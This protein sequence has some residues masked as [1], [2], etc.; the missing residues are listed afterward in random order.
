MHCPCNVTLIAGGVDAGHCNGKGKDAKF[1][2]PAEIVFVDKNLYVCD[3]G[4]GA[5][6]VIDLFSCFVTLRRFHLR[7]TKTR[8][9]RSVQVHDLLISC[10]MEFE[11][12]LS[13]VAIGI[14]TT[15]VLY[16]S[17][18]RLRKV[19]SLSQMYKDV[20]AFKGHLEEL[21]SFPKSALPMALTCTRDGEYLLVGNCDK[22]VGSGVTVVDIASR[23]IK[24]LAVTSPTGL[25]VTS[26][27]QFF[28][29][30]SEKHCVYEY[31]VDEL[32]KGPV[33]GTKYGSVSG[34]RDGRDI[35]WINP[36]GVCSFR[37]TVFVSDTG[38]KAVRLITSRK[39]PVPLKK[40]MSSY[41]DLFGIDR[42]TKDTSNERMEDVRK[43]VRF[44]NNHDGIENNAAI[45]H[46]L[47]T[48]AY[49]AL[50]RAYRNR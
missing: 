33:A 47:S 12:L 40:V 29:V 36:S 1:R 13:P 32:L 25:T 37:I 43:V 15:N 7:T 14:S 17:D 19:F 9:V 46:C 38:N 34:H 27:G 20:D 35:C 4:N 23:T 16:I 28:V 24:T 41:A 42:K 11:G 31:P 22:E 8:C 45:F 26:N 48:R 2:S 44:F 18:I 50:Q 5:I 30:S 21:Y 49:K 6:R 39:A 10:E 3:S